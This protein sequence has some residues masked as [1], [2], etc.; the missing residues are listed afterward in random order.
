[1]SSSTNT[2]ANETVALPQRTFHLFPRLPLELQRKIWEA[3]LEPRILTA[4]EQRTFTRRHFNRSY[5]TWKVFAWGERPIPTCA[6]VV[7]FTVIEGVHPD[8]SPTPFW[9]L[10]YFRRVIED[11]VKDD[12]DAVDPFASRRGN[13][14]KYIMKTPR[15]PAALYVCSESR[16][17]AL[18]RYQ[19]GFAGS[20]RSRSKAFDETFEESGANQR[21][22]W[23]DWERDMI[24]VRILKHTFQSPDEYTKVHNIA[25]V[26]NK[27]WASRGAPSLQVGE[28]PWDVSLVEIVRELVNLKTLVVYYRSS[29]D[30]KT[31]SELSFPEQVKKTILD[32]LAYPQGSLRP[33]AQPL[34]AIKVLQVKMEKLEEALQY[35]NVY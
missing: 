32:V 13:L 21:R 14:E 22:A 1:M 17:I 10:P 23:I 19:L 26:A 6:N 5:P 25:F 12:P 11:S 4:Y 18:G 24:L 29:D 15:G 31:T 9:A 27:S 2:S 7:T 3:S 8:L 16:Q 30:H 20:H 35:K 33:R 34:T 28:R